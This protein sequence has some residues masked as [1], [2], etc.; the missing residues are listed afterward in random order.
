MTTQ[1]RYTRENTPLRIL[2]NVFQTLGKEKADELGL[3]QHRN[4]GFNYKHLRSVE[5]IVG[6]VRVLNVEG[7]CNTSTFE[8]KTYNYGAILGLANMN[9][10][11][12]TTFRSS[13]PAV[14]IPKVSRANARNMSQA[15]RIARL[16]HKTDI[17]E[18]FAEV[19]SRVPST[20]EVNP[21]AAHVFT[22]SMSD[23]TMKPILVI[24]VWG[25]F[26]DDCYWS[27]MKY[28]LENYLALQ[29]EVESED[30]VDEQVQ[31]ETSSPRPPKAKVSEREEAMATV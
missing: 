27:F 11:G 18:S 16:Q 29:D 20:V 19:A 14:I 21:T 12:Q 3:I 26:S 5:Q 9:S 2:N 23:G 24:E 28:P 31:S 1:Q 7:K 4:G 30:E 17:R 25:V 15:E 22:I 13:L 6:N 8:D 10:D